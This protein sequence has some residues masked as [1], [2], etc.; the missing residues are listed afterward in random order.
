[1]PDTGRTNLLPDNTTVVTNANTLKVRQKSTLGHACDVQSDAALLL[2]ETFVHDRIARPR[3]FS[4]NITYF[5]HNFFSVGP[6]TVSLSYPCDKNF[7]C[8]K[9]QYPISSK[10]LPITKQAR[11]LDNSLLKPLE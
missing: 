8:G 2:G 3:A 9:I 1:M 4:T 10:E 6:R 11:D 7:L 5:G